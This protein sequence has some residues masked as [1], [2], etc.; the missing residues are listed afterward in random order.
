MRFVIKAERASKIYG[1][2]KTISR[3]DENQEEDKTKKTKP[4]SY[5]KS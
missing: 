4:S 3:Y 5:E 1:P 2:E